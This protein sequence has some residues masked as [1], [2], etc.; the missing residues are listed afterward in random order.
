M[1]I[2]GERLAPA[3]LE[4]RQKLLAQLVRDRRE[5][6][7]EVALGRL[8]LGAEKQSAPIRSNQ[9][10]SRGELACR[11]ALEAASRAS[12]PAGPRSCAQ[13]GG[14]CEREGEEDR[15]AHHGQL[16][17]DWEAIGR[18]MVMGR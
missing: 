13:A 12:G 9:E 15:M 2:G 3:V 10:Q 6:P 14:D 16:G 7:R 8:P 17:S 4:P 18:Q 1:Q 11:S 5:R